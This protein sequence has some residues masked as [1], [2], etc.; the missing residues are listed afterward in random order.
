VNMF[1]FSSAEGEVQKEID[2]EIAKLGPGFEADPEKMAEV[3]SQ[4]VGATR[5]ISGGGAVLGIIFI[6]LGVPVTKQPVAAA[7]PLHP[8]LHPQPRR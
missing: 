7:H 6:A 2:K 3:K 8:S 1:V 5:L 4:A